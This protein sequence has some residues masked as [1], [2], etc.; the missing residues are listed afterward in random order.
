MKR[1]L[2]LFNILILLPIILLEG[3]R[4]NE[5]ETV[6]QKVTVTKNEEEI[7]DG[8]LTIKNESPC[9]IC[10]R[11]G[12]EYLPFDESLLESNII[13]VQTQKKID[14]VKKDCCIMFYVY[15]HNTFPKDY[16]GWFGYMDNYLENQSILLQS[17]NKDTSIVVFETPIYKVR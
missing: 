6:N 2:L 17:L 15:F 7:D 16:E 14:K 12:D 13:E 4:M 3:C 11:I 1:R 10:Y 9:K 8:L 5:E